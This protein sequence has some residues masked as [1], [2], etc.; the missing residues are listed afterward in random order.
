MG[1]AQAS[2]ARAAADKF[3]RRQIDH[4][5]FHNVTQG[6]ALAH[7]SQVGD[8][9]FRPSPKGTDRLCLS[10]AVAKH[11]G[12]DHPVVMTF[13]ILEK[14]KAEGAAALSLG[15]ELII[16][17]GRHYHEVFEDLDEILASF[18]TPYMRNFNAAV[19]HRKFVAGNAATIREAANQQAGETGRAAICWGHKTEHDGQ[20][21]AL[22]GFF[23]LCCVLSP[24]KKP[25]MDCFQVTP[26]GFWYSQEMRTSLDNVSDAFKRNLKERMRAPSRSQQNARLGYGVP[27]AAADAQYATQSAYAPTAEQQAHPQAYAAAG[28]TQESYAAY[29]AQQRTAAAAYGM[30]V[31]AAAPAAA[32][33]GSAA[34]WAAGGWA[35]PS[36]GHAAAGY[37]SQPGSYP[38]GGASR[39]PAAAWAAGRHASNPPS[40]P[41][42]AG[43]RW[44][45]TA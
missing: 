23:E 40:A 4:P 21:R 15:A 11:Q 13:E 9:I 6:D 42:P 39:V 41:Q 36:S 32:T 3:Q 24:N 18:V 37:G 28:W 29:V 19:G 17:H 7:L 14:K 1:F 8:S 43:L 34:G 16:T 31:Q 35:A 10:I 22:P 25:A 30:Q 45:G 33:N 26:L 5:N 27:Q 20:P 44:D 12:E 38:A 2:K